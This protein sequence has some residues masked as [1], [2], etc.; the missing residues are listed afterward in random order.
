MILP[1]KQFL[2]EEAG[3]DKIDAIV[4]L[5]RADKPVLCDVD[6][7]LQFFRDKKANLGKYGR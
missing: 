2:K 6:A 1:V 4:Q 5:F 3:D 7:K